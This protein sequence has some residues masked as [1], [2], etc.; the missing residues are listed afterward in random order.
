VLDAVYTC[1]LP[2]WQLQ[3]GEAEEKYGHIQTTLEEIYTAG[4]KPAKS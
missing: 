1:R 2:V 3:Q 4:L